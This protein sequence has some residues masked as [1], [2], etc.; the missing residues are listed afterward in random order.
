MPCTALRRCL[1]AALLI[2]L[3]SCA[4]AP[5][6]AG[7]P[8]VIEGVPFYP[9]AVLQCGPASLA[10]V[11]NFWGAGVTTDEIAAAIYSPTARGTLDIDMALFARKKGFEAIQYEGSLEDIRAN[12]DAGRP[13]IVLI[14]LGAWPYRQD[15]FMVAVGY[16]EG[17][18]V[19]NSGKRERLTI[20]LKEFMKTWEKT[21]RWSLLVKPK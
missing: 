15:H 11:M 10:G 1:G 7:P 16:S 18:L 19:V 8:K 14:D 21:G 3:I 12:I 5:R 2:V 13:L 20:P 9:Q 17:G 4:T 6:I